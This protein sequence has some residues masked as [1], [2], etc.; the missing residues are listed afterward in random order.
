MRYGHLKKCAAVVAAAVALCLPGDGLCPGAGAAAQ[1]AEAENA[2]ENVTENVT[3]NLTEDVTESGTG[4]LTARDAAVV[5]NGEAFTLQDFNYYFYAY[6]DSFVQNNEVYLQ[7]M[8]DEGKSLKDQLYDEETKQSWFDY[9]AGCAADSMQQI[10][11][12]SQE[13]EKAGYALS[14]E[15]LAKVDD[16]CDAME[17]FAAMIGKDTDVYLAETYGEGFDEA[18][19]RAHQTRSRLAEEYTALIA[20]QA[21]M[22]DKTVDTWYHDHIRDYTSAAYERFYVKAADY[23]TVPTPGQKEEARAAAAKILQAVEAGAPLEE[24]SAPYKESG[25][26]TSFSDA[27]YEAGTSYGDW[28]FADDRKDGDATLI[29]DGNGFYVMVWHGFSR[30]TY[31]SAD[32]LDIFYPPDEALDDLNEK[33]E[34]SCLEAEDGLAAWQENGAN[35]DAFIA[36]AEKKSDET[37]YAYRYDNVVRGRFGN[38]IDKWLFEEERKAGDCAVLY[39]DA[40]F[41]LVYY[42]GEG[43][44][45]WKQTVRNDIREQHRQAWFDEVMARCECEKN[46]QLLSHAAGY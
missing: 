35:E 17:N 23:G 27:A 44:E 25:T 3:E 46:E 15:G 2:S 21:D 36:L 26:Y 7:Y 9:F 30:E 13:A 38:S 22:G 42:R 10:I 24:A 29:D 20:S 34:T 4:A 14:A 8:F 41:H 33:L 5:I 32:L 12:V 19:Y 28:L 40:G 45:A 6:Y 18:L 31:K 39:S 16:V 1:A 11:A 43:E 37:G